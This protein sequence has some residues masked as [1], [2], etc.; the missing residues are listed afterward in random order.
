MADIDWYRVRSAAFT[1]IRVE[2]PVVTLNEMN[3]KRDNYTPVS[4]DVL[5]ELKRN[6]R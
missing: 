5:A 4:G 3:E 6:R 1:Y 2:F